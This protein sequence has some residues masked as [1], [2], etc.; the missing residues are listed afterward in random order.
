VAGGSGLSSGSLEQM[1]PAFEHDQA[2]R[3]RELISGAA[4]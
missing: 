1:A 3:A 4:T 2:A